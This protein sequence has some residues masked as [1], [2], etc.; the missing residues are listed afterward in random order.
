[1]GKILKKT[2]ELLKKCPKCGSLLKKRNGKYGPFWGCS[3]YPDC[4]YT[5]DI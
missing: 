2:P 5:E 4:R 1:M 3:G